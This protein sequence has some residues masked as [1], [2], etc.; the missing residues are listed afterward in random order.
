MRLR[1]RVLGRPVGKEKTEAK[2]FLK[3]SECGGWIDCRD[4]DWV[5]DHLE[6]LPH[7]PEDQPQ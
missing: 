4:L 6:E 1:G 7:P 3:C 2:H 5:M